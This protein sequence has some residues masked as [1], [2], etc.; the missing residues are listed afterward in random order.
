MDNTYICL[1][2]VYQI[3]F[4]YLVHFSGSDIATL[5]FCLKPGAILKSCQK[6]SPPV[7][8]LSEGFLF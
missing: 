3:R 1:I 2:C 6:T 5:K 7:T 8:C 4:W